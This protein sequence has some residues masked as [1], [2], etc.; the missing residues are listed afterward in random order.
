M[1]RQSHCQQLLNEIDT[2]TLDVARAWAEHIQADG[3]VSESDSSSS[4]DSVIRTPSPPSPMSPMS[5]MS[6]Y[7]SDSSDDSNMSESIK[8]HQHFLHIMGSLAALQEEVEETHCRRGMGS[9][10]I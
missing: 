2:A 5:P 6:L 7:M 9:G 10:V 8:I 3:E 4:E 1:P